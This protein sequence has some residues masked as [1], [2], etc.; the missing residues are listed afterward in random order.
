MKVDKNIG[1][2][3]KKKINDALGINL[4]YKRCHIKNTS[5]NLFGNLDVED[6]LQNYRMVLFCFYKFF[7]NL[8]S[9]IFFQVCY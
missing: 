6:L 5:E 3:L 9:I 7:S 2:T 4:Q 1:T 8:F